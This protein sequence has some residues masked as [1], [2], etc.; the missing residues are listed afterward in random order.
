MTDIVFKLCEQMLQHS[1]EASYKRLNPALRSTLS[2]CIEA[3]LPFLPDTFK[4]VYKE[5]RGHWWFGDGA[6]SCVG[7]RYY[8]LAC[9]VN[10]N[11]AC[12]SFEQFAG[13]PGVLWEED[14][15]APSRLHVGERFSWR[16]YYVEITSMRTDSL[17]ACTYRESRNPSDGLKVGAE[18]GDY[19]KPHVITSVKKVVGGTVIRAVKANK[20][21]SGSREVAKRFT[22][23]YAELSAFRKTEK[24]RVKKI[25]EQIASCDPAKDG[26]RISKQVAAEHF[27][28]FQ[29]EEINAAFTKRKD[30]CANEDRIKAWR[31]GKGDPWLDFKGI[32]L[33]VKADRVE[34]SNGNSASLSAVRRVLPVLL[35][36]RKSPG[37]LSLPLD[38]YTIHNVSK[39][40]VRVGCTLAPWPEVER[41]ASI[42]KPGV[43]L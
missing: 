25:I 26:E 27:R 21:Y 10:H 20:P 19:N 42:L 23:T 11:S 29:L 3:D 41:I 24:Q 22:V 31:V 18:I 43:S 16:G 36:R 35:D 15:K 5:L 38:G 14:S 17:V 1:P 9:A 34:C 7:E 37:E 6:G 12:Q 13:R 40:G 39:D 4:R 32:M 30:W 2:S 8:S 28:H 33:R